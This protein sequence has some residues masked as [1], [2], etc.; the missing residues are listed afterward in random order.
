MIQFIECLPH[1]HEELSWVPRAHISK[2]TGAV[3]YTCTPSSEET[4][5][6]LSG[7][8]LANSFSQDRELQVQ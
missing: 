6:R 4:D 8:L 5:R 2:K 1:K 7:H 3:T